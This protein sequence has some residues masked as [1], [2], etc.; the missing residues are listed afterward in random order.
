M[1]IPSESNPSDWPSRGRKYRVAR[2]RHR[3][4]TRVKGKFDKQSKQER[5]WTATAKAWKTLVDCGLVSDG[6]S[7]DETDESSSCVLDVS[8]PGLIGP[9][10][11]W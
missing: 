5:I 4:L 1:Y 10:D 9:P 7:T 11:E 3:N 8:L 6:D 2:A